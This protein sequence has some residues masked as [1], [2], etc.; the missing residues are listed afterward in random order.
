M[1][2]NFGEGIIKVEEVRV[3]IVCEEEPCLTT[4]T[5]LTSSVLS[6]FTASS[7]LDLAPSLEFLALVS[8]WAASIIMVSALPDPSSLGVATLDSSACAS[9]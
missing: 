3:A 8:S 4:L 7:K 2:M 1:H 5:I 9:S 6:S